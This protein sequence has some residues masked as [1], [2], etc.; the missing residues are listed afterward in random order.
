MGLFRLITI[1]LVALIIWRTVK[2]YQAKKAAAKPKAKISVKEKMVKCEYCSVHIP[3]ADAVTAGK[4]WFCN[5]Q[6]REL[7]EQGD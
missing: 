2:N 1:I 7:Y 3:E 5:T 6:H 4:L